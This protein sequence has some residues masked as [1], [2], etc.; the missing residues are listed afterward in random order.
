MPTVTDTIA[1]DPYRGA[2]VDLTGVVLVLDTLLPSPP[3]S[4]VGRWVLLRSGD[5]E[6]R[7]RIFA[8]THH[9]TASSLLL[10]GLTRADVPIGSWVEV[11]PR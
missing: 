4:L 8:A 11:E 6:R 1:I 10:L 2:G 9:G 5:R 3:G 7:E